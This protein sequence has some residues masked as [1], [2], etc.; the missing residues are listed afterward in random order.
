MTLAMPPVRIVLV[1]TSHP[2][3]I[4]AAARAMKTMGLSRLVLVDPREFPHPE[5]TALAAGAD[6]VLDQ[7]VIVPTLTQALGDCQLALGCTA[8]SRH[9]ALP[10][11]DPRAA[12]ARARAAS[13]QGGVALV[14]GNERT[15]LTNEELQACHTAV[16]I[17][18]D[19]AFGSL[20]LAAAVQVLAYELRMAT[21]A[22]VAAPIT[23]EARQDARE[24]DATMAELEG[25]FAHL[26]RVLFDIDF[27]KGRS[28]RT[29]MQRLRRMF[30]RAGLSDREV[31]ILRGVFSEAQRCARLAGIVP[32][33]IEDGRSRSA[34]DADTDNP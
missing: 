18:A 30:L 6:D 26:E 20:N 1:R 22:G 7:A 25:L 33:P 9:V 5:A 8:R 31:F 23:P 13:A 11:L 12:A 14:F 21:L 2:G 28:P 19:P 4:G 24:P 16:H 10:E 27:F 29:I 17:P 15:G 3:N 32:R 34:H